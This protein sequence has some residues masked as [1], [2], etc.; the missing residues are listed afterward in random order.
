MPQ[1]NAKAPMTHLPAAPNVVSNV[2]VP[3]G[4]TAPRIIAATPP[5]KRPLVLAGATVSIDPT[6]HTPQNVIDL[7]NG[8]N[9]GGVTASLDRYGQLQINGVGN[10]GGDN[11]LLMHLGLV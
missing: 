5:G 10:V 9:I 3:A 8:A 6:S 1:V 11:L 7:I 2:S 4:N